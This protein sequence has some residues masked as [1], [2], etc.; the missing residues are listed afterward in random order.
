VVAFRPT[1]RKAGSVKAEK[2]QPVAGDVHVDYTGRRAEQLGHLYRGDEGFTYSRLLVLSNWRTFSQ[3]PQDWPLAVCDSRSIKD[4]EGLIN[5][6]IYQDE[7][8][9]VENLGPIPEKGIIGEGYG[10]PYQEGHEWCY[11]SHMNRDELL[12][13]KLNDSDHQRV[14][15]TP[16]CAF[17]NPEKGAVPRES[18]E[19][20]TCC[21]FQ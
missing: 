19:V 12:T 9:D 13:F 1:I 6:L 18:I 21:Y 20:R 5:T 7:V 15:R 17:Y 14:W 3:P 8:P 4:E 11:F 2:D 16:H 10:F